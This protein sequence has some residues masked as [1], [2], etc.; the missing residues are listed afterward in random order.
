MAVATPRNPATPTRAL[1]VVGK[2][3]R[4][5]DAE[6]WVEPIKWVALAVFIAV[7]VFAHTQMMENV[8]GRIVWTVV[9]AGIPLFIVLIGYHRWRR[10]CPLA[11]FA[12]IPVRLKRPGILK[13]QPW[14][15]KNYYYVSFGVFFF[16]LWVRLIATNGDGHAISAFF[17]MIAL[18][19]LIFG[20]F[21]TGKT[22]CNY[23]C[24][25]SFIEKIYTEPHG[26]RETKNSQCTKCTACKKSCPDINEENG[27]WKE[28]DSK[29]K[30]FVYFA[31]PGLV[32][33]FY[34]YYYLQ[35]GTWGYYFDGAWTH[36]PMVAH[37]AFMPGRNAETAGFF[38]WQGVPR[39]VA[40]ILTLAVCALFS[41]IL[42]SLLERPIGNWMRRRDPEMEAGRVRHVMM[43]LTAFTAF[44]TFYTFAGAPTL[45]RAPWAVPHIF[46]IVMALTATLYLARRIRR[47]QTTFAEETLARNVIK[48]WEWT[49]KPPRDLHEA[50]LLHTIRTRESTKGA[51]Q[52]VEIYKDAVREALANGF[53]TRE[54]VQLLESLRNQLQIKKA[55]HDK[56]MAA[57]A[58]EERALLSDPTKQISA[59]K[60][61]QL[62]TYRHALENYLDRV[63]A[64]EGTYDDS[65]IV[66]LRSEYRVTREEH[67]AVLQEVLGEDREMAARL[68][69]QAAVVERAAQTIQALELQPSPA[70]DFLRDLLRRKRSRAVDSLVRGLSFMIEEETSQT[71]RQG[72]FSSDLG[73]R[74][75]VIEKLRSIVTPSIA[76]KLLTTYR[77]TVLSESS[78]PTLTE[79]LQARTDDA[80]PYVRAVALYALGERGA[81]R[82][83]LLDRLIADEHELVRETALHLK[84]RGGTDSG[85]HHQL[86]TIEKMIALRSAPIFSTI[87]PE[88]LAELAR[89]SIED[90]YA[91]GNTLCVEG[92]Q[93]NE[94]FILLK[95]EVKILKHDA[96]GERFIGT[97]K[98]GGFIGEMAI[99]D[100]AP[101]SATLVAG[102][103]GTR[104]LRLNGVAFRDSLNRDSTIASSVIRTLAQRLRRQ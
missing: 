26:L 30:R 40:A 16:S 34:F 56:V 3:P 89:A 18:A 44:V 25:L 10:L 59:E 41:Y 63:L 14:L 93:G 57:L 50:F 78:M 65:F 87:S 7:P 53:V 15:E 46:I 80:D 86:I 62:Q 99:L 8:A 31:F 82:D 92:E 79:M 81:A 38:F 24:P 32:F 72:L 20:V 19:A 17:V 27:Y 29:P 43:T 23:I 49:D 66:Q 95:G 36:Q 91:P 6:W 100:P 75:T 96:D 84:E 101:R 48:R 77:E 88:G 73:E 42:F 47:K 5:A 55:D 68:A 22:W 83:E 64:A 21:Y 54:E 35:A 45:W 76:E 33:G 70:H 4:E 37:W 1:P 90:E 97:E 28:L 9:V 12:Q 67:A 71:V 85:E 61:L 69:E 39:A 60:R 102:D 11:F 104:A 94:V 2:K 103:E 13:A 52:V 51:V 58:E 98:A 74:E